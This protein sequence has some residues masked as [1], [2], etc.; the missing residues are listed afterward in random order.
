MA[1]ALGKRTFVA[2][3][4]DPFGD[5]AWH[6]VL[7]VDS[8]GWR[9]RCGRMVPRSTTT[10]VVDMDDDA[11]WPGEY[12]PTCEAHAADRWAQTAGVRALLGMPFDQLTAQELGW[13][14]AAYIGALGVQV[15]RDQLLEAEGTKDALAAIIDEFVRRSRDLDPV[16]P[17]REGTPQPED[18]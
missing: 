2:T 6:Q 15:R 18:P 9:V 8:S 12:C 13:V 14:A 10:T 16:I 11:R 17:R 5:Q 7:G 1:D 4:D 3:P